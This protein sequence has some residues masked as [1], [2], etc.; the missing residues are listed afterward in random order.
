MAPLVGGMHRSDAHKLLPRLIEIDPPELK[1]LYRRL[2]G[3]AAPGAP[4]LAAAGSAGDPS[5]LPVAPPA[6]PAAPHFGA[7][8]LLVR[9]HALTPAKDGVSNRR[10]ISAIETA[11]HSPEVF[12]QEVV[13]AVRDLGRDLGRLGVSAGDFG[14]TLE[15]VHA[16]FAARTA[17]SWL[18]W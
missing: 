9:L 8:E 14:G 4:G 11:L 5:Q 7:T 13:A 16:R 17:P 12:K 15:R 3:L 6:A 10:L 18:R 2:T 1:R